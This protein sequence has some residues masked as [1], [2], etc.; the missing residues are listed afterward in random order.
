MSCVPASTL[1]ICSGIGPSWPGVEHVDLHRA[2]GKPRD[3]RS[4]RIRTHARMACLCVHVAE[5]QRE[6]LRGRTA[7]Q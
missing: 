4:E 2:V 1:R 7:G 3:G 6:F 5:P